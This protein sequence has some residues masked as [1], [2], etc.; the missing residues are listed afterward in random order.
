MDERDLAFRDDVRRRYN[1]VTE[2]WDAGD[3]WHLEVRRRIRRSVAGLVLRHPEPFPL[4][5]DVGSGGV[6]Q[7]VPHAE[8]LQLDLAEARL[9]EERLRVCADARAMPLPNG[10]A[11]C[12]LCVGSVANYCTLVELAQELGRTCS[13]GGYLLFH[14]ELSN[15]LEYVGTAAFGARAAMVTTHYKHQPEVTWVYSATAVRQALSEAG[16]SILKSDYFH[17]ASALAHRIGSRPDRA[18]RWARLDPGPFPNSRREIL[19]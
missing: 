10:I 2:I 15:S 11:S 13:A 1:R 6:A 16:F 18:T 19:C 12:L 3:T 8:Y 5:V 4:V 9:G 17:I 7:R 14:V